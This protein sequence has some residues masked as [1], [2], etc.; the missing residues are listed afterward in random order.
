MNLP[1][2]LS[3]EAD[4]GFVEAAAWYEQ[5]T[6]RGEELIERVRTRWS[7]SAGRRSFTRRFFAM[8]DVHGEG[9]TRMAGGVEPRSEPVRL[10]LTHDEALVLFEF[11][12]RF[13][14]EDSLVIRN[15]AEQRAL[16]NLQALLE[17]SLVDPF[18]PDYEALVVAARDRLRDPAE[19]SR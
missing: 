3:P 4:R 9:R 13:Q 15:Q 14:D 10:Q 2:I 6:G 5:H 11:L 12:T 1:V 18:K 19:N 7:G 17:T 16:W 8:F